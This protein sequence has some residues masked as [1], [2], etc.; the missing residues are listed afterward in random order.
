M[1]GVVISGPLA[2]TDV[3]ALCERVRV[4]LEGCEAAVLVCDA[5]A[6]H[7]DVATLGA[8]ARLQLTARRRG[9][10]IQLHVP[11]RELRALLDLC[12]LAD[13]LP[14]SPGLRLEPVRQAEEREQARGVEERVERGD[15]PV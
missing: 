12:G 11:S 14:V 10:R 1:L 13:L 5:G 4:Q 2:P 3:A 15:P 9:H 8:L 7:A 6:L